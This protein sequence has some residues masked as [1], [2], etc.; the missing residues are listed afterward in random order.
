MSNL[1]GKW[2]EERDLGGKTLEKLLGHWFCVHRTR[3]KT[4]RQV[5]CITW[6]AWKYGETVRKLDLLFSLREREGVWRCEARWG[7]GSKTR[8]GSQSLFDL[9]TPVFLFPLSIY[10]VHLDWIFWGTGCWA[11]N[12]PW[13]IHVSFLAAPLNMS[14]ALCIVTSERTFRLLFPGTLGHYWSRQ[15]CHVSQYDALHTSTRVLAMVGT[16]LISATIFEKAN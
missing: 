3:R 2:A 14:S 16:Q 13:F 4:W 6:A 1:C 12:H 15:C 9:K 5:P 11:Q 7:S 10:L 8:A